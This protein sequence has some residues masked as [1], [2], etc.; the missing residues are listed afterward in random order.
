[1]RHSKTI[2]VGDKSVVVLEVSVAQF[3]DVLAVLG[4]IPTNKMAVDVVAL[5]QTVFGSDDGPARRLLHGATDLGKGIDAC[6]G[7]ALL[8]I[9][10]AWVEVNQPFFDRL[11][12]LPAKLLAP[13]NP[14]APAG[15]T[16]L[17]PEAV[18]QAA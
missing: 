13:A 18:E 1:M 16:D 3:G 7:L 6:G 9:A 11:T 14:A 17:P 12:A 8:D 4:L 15:G 5:A 10:D 2:P